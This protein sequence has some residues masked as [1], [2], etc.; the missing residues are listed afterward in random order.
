MPIHRC[1]KCFEKLEEKA[2]NSAKGLIKEGF[3]ENMV[4]ERVLK[5]DW[6]SKGKG[7]CGYKHGG[8]TEQNIFRKLRVVHYV[9]NKRL[10]GRR[11]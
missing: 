8:I 4:L 7:Y 2:T 1:T 5:N 10:L 6:K 9:Q 3:R 11:G